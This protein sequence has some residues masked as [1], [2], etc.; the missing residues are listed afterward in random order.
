MNKSSS[1]IG[2][3]KGLKSENDIRKLNLE[4]MFKFENFTPRT[5]MLLQ[6][7]INDIDYSPNYSLTRK[8]DDKLCMN[9][10]KMTSRTPIGYKRNVSSNRKIGSNY[11]DFIVER[12]LKSAQPK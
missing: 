7:E 4:N 10:N 5:D 2:I 3:R 8:R 9:F 1:S 11:A 6:N 12:K